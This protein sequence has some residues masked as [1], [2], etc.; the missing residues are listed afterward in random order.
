MWSARKTLFISLSDQSDLCMRMGS[1]NSGMV[2][3]K[4]LFYFI[5]F[6]INCQDMTYL[7]VRCEAARASRFVRG[8]GP[9]VS[10]RVGGWVSE[11][12][13]HGWFVGFWCW[14]EMETYVSCL[15][16]I[17]M[18]YGVYIVVFSFVH[19]CARRIP[20][21]VRKAK[22]EAKPLLSA[23][24]GFRR[25]RPYICFSSW[26]MSDSNWSLPS[27]ISQCHIPK[28]DRVFLPSGSSSILRL[29]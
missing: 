26:K 13:R 15:I 7:H 16:P 3:E 10:C 18:S 19:Y 21:T 25:L 23:C 2:W 29:C 11:W 24:R 27:N 28:F 4:N 1:V 8:G 14:M 6:W 17:P 22:S 9:S 20:R 5:F 12:V